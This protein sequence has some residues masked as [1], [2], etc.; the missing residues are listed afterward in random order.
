MQAVGKI[1][2]I[3]TIQIIRRNIYGA[4]YGRDFSPHFF[5]LEN[6]KLEVN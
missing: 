3:F 4:T 5:S 1:S 6:R 2:K